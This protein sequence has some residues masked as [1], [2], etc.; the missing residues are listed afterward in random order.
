MDS[1][2]QLQSDQLKQEEDANGGMIFIAVSSQY[3][4]FQLL[5]RSRYQQNLDTSNNFKPIERASNQQIQKC[6]EERLFNS[7]SRN[8]TF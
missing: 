6:L 4:V 7:K 2:L 1:E 3:R 5:K 8:I